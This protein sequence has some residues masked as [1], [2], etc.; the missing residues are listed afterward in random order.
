M[1]LPHEVDARM[2]EIDAGGA[3]VGVLDSAFC[4][5]LARHTSRLEDVE[6]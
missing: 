4:R 3:V 6:R 1:L 5:S 2:E